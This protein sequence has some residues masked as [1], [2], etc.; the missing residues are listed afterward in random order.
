MAKNDPYA[1]LRIPQFR[2]FLI[3]RFGLVFA[4]AMQFVV[5]EW[6]IY[7]LTK[8]PFSLGVIGLMEVIPAVSM[9]M[10]A[11]HFVDQ[12]EKRNLLV[13][14]ILA[15]LVISTGLFLLTWPRITE[16]MKT[17]SI[18]WGVYGLVFLGGIVRSFIGPTVF[19]LFSLVVPKQTYAN[20]ATW[21]SG[22]RTRPAPQRSRSRTGSTGGVVRDQSPSGCSARGCASWTTASPGRCGSAEGEGDCAARG[23]L[24]GSFSGPGARSGRRRSGW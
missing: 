20:G 10:F 18:V 13:K 17:D 24:G 21:S 16:G 8:D 2:T 14:C 6:E 5:I 1:A 3:L 7:N 9:A 15:F 19:S 11:G 4:W 22:T 23:Q 12:S